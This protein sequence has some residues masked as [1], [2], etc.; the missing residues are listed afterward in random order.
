MDALDRVRDAGTHL[1]DR[2]DAAL[3]TL[4]AAPAHPVWSLTRRLAVTP[5]PAA[6]DVAAL[7]A[8]DLRRAADALHR[9]EAA[10]HARVD[11]LPPRLDGSGTPARAYE[12]V[13]SAL[14]A[15]LSG[16]GD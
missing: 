8:T 16:P 10:R 7:D 15:A 13:W 3:L 11:A 14:S 2:V 5:A 9:A 6:R 1:F 4:G 12:T